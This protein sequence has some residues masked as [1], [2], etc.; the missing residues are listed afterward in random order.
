MQESPDAAKHTMKPYLIGFGLAVLLT[1]IPFEL[2]ATKALSR[3]STMI[4]IAILA[5]AQGAVHL[6]YFLH[7]DLKSAS[8][9]RL[10]VLMFAAAVV[11]LM[12]GGTLWIMADLNY[13]MGM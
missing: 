13:R 3:T 4:V 11:L 5:L 6:H 9:E 7:L 2:V 10:V 8:R 12:A 1:V